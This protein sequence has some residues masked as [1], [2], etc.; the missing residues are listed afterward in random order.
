MKKAF[1]FIALCAMLFCLAGCGGKP[2]TAIDGTPWNKDWHTIDRTLGIEKLGHG[3]TL[4]EEKSSKDL[5]N[6]C[7]SIGGAQT[8]VNATGAST[9]V[10]DAQLTLLLA[11]H[12][13]EDAARMN[14]DNWLALADAT[15]TVDDIVTQTYNEQE[16]I[17]MTYVFPPDTSAYERGASAF[18]TFNGSA[19]SVEFVCQSS[20]AEDAGEVLADVL[21][22]CHYAA[23]D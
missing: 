4:R 21:A 11:S 2:E 17:V 12:G 1:S 7:W 15:Y 5:F 22:H 14:V 13:S 9:T 20:F 10:Y 18:T 8:Y 19:I 16:Y 23:E 6:N 3:L